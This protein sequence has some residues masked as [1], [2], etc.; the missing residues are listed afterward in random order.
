MSTGMAGPDP[1]I[2]VIDDDASFRS[3]VGR[4]LEASGYRVTLYESGEQFL[5]SPLCTD[6]GCILLDLRMAGLDGLQLQQRLADVQTLLPVIFLTGHGDIP[7]SVQAMKSGAEDFLVKPV[8]KA[9]LLD[10]IERALSRYAELR[11]QFNRIAQIRRRVDLLSPREREVYLLFASGKQNKQIA[12]ELGKSV[13]T[14]KAQRQSIMQKLGVRSTAEAV[15]MAEKL[16][17]LVATES[18]SAKPD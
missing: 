17:L 15:S 3:S 4:L 10:A 18:N 12:H 14:I 9:A 11:E 7:A 16:G 13:R 1:V 8:S 6:P 5:R 2:H